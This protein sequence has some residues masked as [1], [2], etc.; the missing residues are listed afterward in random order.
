M[1]RKEGETHWVGGTT[2]VGMGLK[3]GEGLVWVGHGRKGRSGGITKSQRKNKKQ[4][5][6]ERGIE[7]RGNARNTTG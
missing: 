2:L 3:G 7:H 1:R 6:D 4:N 5:L